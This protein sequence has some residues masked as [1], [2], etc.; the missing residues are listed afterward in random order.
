MQI[1]EGVC[2]PPRWKA[3]VDNTL[4]DLYN[5]YISYERRIHQLLLLFIQNNS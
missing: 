1:E 5:C 2:Y 4:R 3:E